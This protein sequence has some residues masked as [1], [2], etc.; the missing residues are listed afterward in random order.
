MDTPPD[1]TDKPPKVT[2]SELRGVLSSCKAFISF[3]DNNYD[4]LARE[5]KREFAPAGKQLLKQ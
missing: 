1:S 5:A 4:E 2:A 3:T